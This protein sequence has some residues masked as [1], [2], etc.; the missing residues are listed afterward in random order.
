MTDFKIPSFFILFLTFV[1]LWVYNSKKR[2]KIHDAERQAF[3]KRE[4]ESLIVRKKE[5][6]SE[7]YF[8][9]DISQLEFPIYK[10]D[11]AAQQKAG[12]LKQQ[13]E[14]SVNLPMLSLSELTNTDIRFNFGTANQ[15]FITQAEENYQAFLGFL[16][17]Y[18]LLAK[19][20]SLIEEAIASLE[21][22][23]RLKSDISKHYMLLA[24]LYMETSNPYGVKKLLIL[25]EDL[26]SPSKPKIVEYL[27][28]LL[29]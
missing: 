19:E 6:P 23:I 17:D 22:A 18:A 8:K 28:R 20:Q 21:E 13:L 24:D 9:P 5:I 14:N 3:W 1:F 2:Q 10:L 29:A 25:A 27:N 15:P 16:Y 26:T 12:K 7:L 4:E 11:I